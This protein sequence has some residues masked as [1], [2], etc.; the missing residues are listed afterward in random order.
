MIRHFTA[1]TVVLDSHERVLL[2]HHNKLGMWLYPG[3]HID[4]NEAPAEAA[5][6]EVVEET[7]IRAE[8]IC[9][10][11]AT[12]AGLRSHI[13]PYAIVEM[14]VTDS[15]HGDHFHIDHVYVARPLGGE[16]T[17]QLGEVSAVR[18]FELA[19]LDD[20]HTPPELPKMIID[21]ADWA[22]TRN[23]G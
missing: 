14:A 12:Y 7:G 1:S 9:D 2:V 3:G 5:L 20:L 23:L 11:I 16:V 15:K 13:P 4:D 21:A 6:R 18:W 17:A 10:P 22:R 19:D 8:L